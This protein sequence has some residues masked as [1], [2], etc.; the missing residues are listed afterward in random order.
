MDVPGTPELPGTLWSVWTH[1]LPCGSIRRPSGLEYVSPSILP[2]RLEPPDW[3]SG[4]PAR[5]TISHVNFVA[6]GELPSS[7]HLMMRSEEHQS[8]IQSLMRIS[9]AVFCLKKKKIKTQPQH[10]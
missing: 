2:T 7:Y 10:I 9:Y 3:R 6:S 1:S 8:E 4:S 5:T